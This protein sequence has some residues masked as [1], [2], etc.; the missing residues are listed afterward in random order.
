MDDSN[1]SVTFLLLCLECLTF[2]GGVG[3]KQ[4]PWKYKIK[5]VNVQERA[6]KK[7]VFGKTL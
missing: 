6:L 7:N 5:L 1:N 4:G 3:K 2:E